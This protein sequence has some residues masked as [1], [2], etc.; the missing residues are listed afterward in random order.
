[1]KC[2]RIILLIAAFVFIVSPS[3]SSRVHA[4]TNPNPDVGKPCKLTDG[5][6]GTFVLNTSQNIVCQQ[7]NPGSK[8]PRQEL[9]AEGSLPSDKS[10]NTSPGSL[11]I[12]GGSTCGD[13]KGVISTGFVRQVLCKDDGALA[14]PSIIENLANYII[15]L[16][17]FILILFIA[18]A[19][20]QI[21]TAGG[22]PEAL[23]AGKRRLTLAISSIALLVMS[24]L[25]LDL[26]GITGGNF[27][28]VPIKD[29]FN[30]DTIPKIILAITGYV[31]FFG[32]VLSTAM[33]I[34]GGVVM[35]TSA[36]SP[37]KIQQARRAITYAIIGLAIVAG[38]GLIYT[39][40][41]KAI[42][43]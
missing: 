18:I 12:G 1:M 42:V 33:V 37:Q 34:Y 43:G 5:A 2:L 17:S 29:G 19:G 26:L 25:V 13:L 27:L 31:L 22:S 32:G 39:L 28:G 20:V 14:I 3:G 41:S 10:T 4:A 24:R 15:S 23:K 9:P 38:A 35:I 30:Q 21:M 40:V 16:G 8:A 6:D 11:T 7:N 36:G